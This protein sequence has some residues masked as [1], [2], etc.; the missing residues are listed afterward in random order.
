METI[1]AIII[2]V[3][4]IT[5]GFFPSFLI[6]ILLHKHIQQMPRK[7]TK[8]MALSGA[9]AVL[10][11]PTAYGYAGIFPAILVL[12]FTEQRIWGLASILIIFVVSLP[13]SY[14]YI[15]RRHAG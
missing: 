11:S 5:I 6:Y 14:W 1:S 10:F 2:A 13:F 3:V 7:F 15:S 8:S 4:F 12:I 9:L